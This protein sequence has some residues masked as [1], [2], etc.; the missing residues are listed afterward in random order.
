MAGKWV[1]VR[2]KQGTSSISGLPNNNI[3]QIKIIDANTISFRELIAGSIYHG[4][5]IIAAGTGTGH[6]LTPQFAFE[7]VTVIGANAQPTK[8]NQVVLGDENVD[9]VIAGGKKLAFE[10]EI[11]IG[12]RNLLANSRVEKYN[13]REYITYA[14]IA[15]IF[16]EHGIGQYTFSFDLKSDVA[17]SISVYCQ[18]GDDLKY[19]YQPKIFF[20]TAEYQRFSMTVN[21]TVEDILDTKT[22]LSFYG[23]YG[24]GRFPSVKKVKI[25]K[26][27]KA[28]DWGPA[29]EDTLLKGTNGRYNLGTA[30]YYADN[31][32]AITG[33]L[34]VGD[35]YVTPTGENRTVV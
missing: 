14:N 16:D 28:T 23:A 21:V 9:E 35:M 6:I 32:D 27:T 7:N 8:D 13:A 4:V 1:N 31:A 19:T 5:N 12:G 3:Y 25:E 33:G 17:G 20:A 10:D 15:S 24:T 34:V 30:T 11:L 29:L 18:D 2:Y 22:N 26:G